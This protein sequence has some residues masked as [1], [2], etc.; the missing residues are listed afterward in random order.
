M[1]EPRLKIILEAVDNASK[2]LKSG[3]E[4]ITGSAK[5]AGLA[6]S[7]AGA[8]ITGALALAAKSAMDEEIGIRKLDS[9]LRTANTTYAEQQKAI[10]GVITALQ[11][12]T[13]FGDEAQRQALTKLVALTGS[14]SDSLAA[15]PVVLDVAAG[16]EMDLSAASLLVAKAL[17]GN[18]SALS[19]YGITLKEGATQTEIM[20]ALTAK[21]GGAAEAA[22]DPLVGL[23]NRVGDVVQALGKALLPILIPLL[24]KL[25]ELANAVQAWVEENPELARTIV[26]IVAALGAFMVVMGPLLLML[27]TLPAIIAGIGVAITI[28]TGPIG[29][30]ALAIM[31]LIVVGG[32]LIANWGTISKKAKELWELVPSPIRDV[33]ESIVAFVGEN[34][35]KMLAIMFPAIGLPI[36]IARNWGPIVDFVTG[37]WETITTAFRDGV[38]GLIGFA[39]SWANAWVSGANAI[40]RALN[41]I[42]VSIPDWV[43]IIGGRSF[44]LNLPT[45][46]TITLP[47]LDMGGIVTAPTIAALAVN[48]KPEAVIPLDKLRGM[49][50]NIT[51]IVEGPIYGM[52]D[53]ERRIGE[54]IVSLVRRGGLA[55]VLTG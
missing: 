39:E 21:F 4:S 54:S 34:W 26:L 15:L 40:I 27:A 16:L 18:T 7:A 30:I 45:V 3:L 11:N 1:A 33:L 48:R 17:A 20:A 38:N 28:A 42:K 36:L 51:I 49:R 53:F 12:K 24:T 31:G 6:M 37:M 5:T 43:P 44:G 55:G 47:R 29:L 2:T 9:A 13:N 10:E 19:R 8:V 52:E 22:R 25:E 23:N 46:P 32:L 35:D 41:T 50:P 14:Y